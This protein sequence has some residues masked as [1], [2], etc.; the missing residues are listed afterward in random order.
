M[1]RGLHSHPAVT[2]QMPCP[3]LPYCSAP[4]MGPTVVIQLVVVASVAVLAFD[5]IK[6]K[7]GQRW[8]ATIAG[9]TVFGFIVEWLN[10]RDPST[11]IYCYPTG[12]E[13]PWYLVNLWDVPVWVPLGWGG[14]IYASTWTAQRLRLPF[15]ARP[16]AAAFLAVNIDFSLDPIAN[17]VGFWRW[18]YFTVNFGGVPYDNFAAWYLIVLIYSFSV[19]YCLYWTKKARWWSPTRR[20]PKDLWYQWLIPLVGAV[21]AGLAFYAVKVVLPELV[22][23]YSCDSGSMAGKIFLGATMAAALITW[24]ASRSPIDEEPAVNLP[25]IAVPVAIHV[26]CLGIFLAYVPWEG[27]AFGGGQSMLLAAIP[28]Q[29]IAG[30][31][32]F[33]SPWLRRPTLPRP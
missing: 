25:V 31:L 32:V 1:P 14:I 3:P 4:E 18:K 28:I 19:A 24:L 2:T 23:A 29:L 6:Q 26:T 11:S 16:C 8:L 22:P 15:W 7:R 12:S 33:A 5:A 17:A 13:K 21:L 10:T 27:T 9:G 20:T 30:A